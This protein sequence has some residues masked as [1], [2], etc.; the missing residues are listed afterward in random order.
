MGALQIRSGLQIVAGIGETG[1]TILIVI[2]AVLTVAFVLSAVFGNRAG[3][4]VAV[5]HQHG[6]GPGAGVF[7]FVVGPTVFILNVIPTALGS[8]FGD[9]AM[10]S[11]RSGAEG[12][13]VNTWLQRW[14]GLLLGVVLSS[15]AFLGMFIA[16]ISR[17]RTIRQFVTGVC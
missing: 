15:T 6:A 14:I 11:A 1:N 13:A 2:I 12:V 8:Y 10:M 5:E 3:H 9:M 16:R 4:P 7:V 17:G